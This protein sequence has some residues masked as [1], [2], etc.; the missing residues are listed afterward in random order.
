MAIVT[1]GCM[2]CGYFMVRPPVSWLRRPS[3]Y[4][5]PGCFVEI[6]VVEGERAVEAMC[7]EMRGEVGD[8]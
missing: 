3:R 8:R 6:D 5:C 1:F 4:Y 7:D 2:S